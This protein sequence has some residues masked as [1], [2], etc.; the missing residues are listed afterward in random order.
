[1]R[2]DGPTRV[3]LLDDDLRYLELVQ[4]MLEAE[5]FEVHTDTSGAR[6]MA[7][8]S[9][10]KPDVVV[11]DI[12]MGEHNGIE[13]ARQVRASEVGAKIPILFVSAWTGRP[14]NRMPA[15]TTRLFKPFTQSEICGAIRSILTK[16]ENV[17]ATEERSDV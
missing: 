15:N 3:L 5:G 11:L 16:A 8:I 12:M 2:T 13:L 4:L 14:D 17:G 9:Q 10:Q 1:M 7:K 6:L